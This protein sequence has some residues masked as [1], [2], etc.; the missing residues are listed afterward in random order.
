MMTNT[1]ARK[2]SLLPFISTSPIL[3]A[4]T[5]V[6]LYLIT[7]P[8]TA[9][10]LVN[11]VRVTRDSATLQ[12]NPPVSDGGSPITNYLIY[13]RVMPH[14]TWEEVSLVGLSKALATQYV[15][16]HMGQKVKL[17]FSNQNTRVFE[18]AETGKLPLF[19]IAIQQ[20]CNHFSLNSSLKVLHLLQILGWQSE[21]THYELH[22]NQSERRQESLLLRTCCKQ[23]R[24][25]HISWYHETSCTK[26][27]HQ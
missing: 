19:Y 5:K 20:R 1:S 17:K 27:S 4:E 12:W 6:L 3:Y 7:V 9:P 26:E 25:V 24:Q 15:F 2:T 10:N 23:E 22:S 11:V 18:K 14:E 8:P 13:K 21:R 16:C